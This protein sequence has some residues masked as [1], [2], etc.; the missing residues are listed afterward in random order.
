MKQIMIDVAKVLILF[1][2]T[3]PLFVWLFQRF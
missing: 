3:L 1:T 2:I